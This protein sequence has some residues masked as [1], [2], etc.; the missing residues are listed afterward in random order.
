MANTINYADQFSQF[1]VQ[2]YEAESKSYG[3]LKSNPQVQWLNAKTIKLPVITLTGYK[4]HTRTIGFNAGNLTNTWEA[5]TLG[6]DRDVEFFIDAM[7]VNE[8]NLVASVANIQNVF[9]TEQAIPESDAYRFSKLYADYVNAE[10]GNEDADTEGLSSTNILAKFDEWMSEMD[11]EGVPEEGR[12][13]YVIPAV[14]RLLKEA[15]GLT[16]Y[17]QV[18]PNNGQVYRGIH[19]LDDVQIVSVPSARMKT[20]YD[21]TTGFEPAAGALQ[22]SAI[23]VH[24]NSV[25]ARERYDYI[26]MFAPGTDSRT[27]SGYIYQNRKYQDL[28]LLKQRVAGVKIS[29]GAVGSGS[30]GEE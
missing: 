8:T 24:P 30:E 16:R 26:K 13:L 5:K 23:L 21:F 25:V 14:N 2:K 4:D 12:I 9:E 6:F 1:L 3:L 20:A 18:N 19:T 27:G 28:F 15:E 17:L 22:M 11:D 7:D 10:I 29:V